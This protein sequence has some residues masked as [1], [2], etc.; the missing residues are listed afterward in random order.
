MYY[1]HSAGDFLGYIALTIHF[2]YFPGNLAHTKGKGINTMRSPRTPTRTITFA[3]VH[4]LSC[5]TIFD[6]QHLFRNLIYL[7]FPLNYTSPCIN[8][9]FQ[10]CYFNFSHL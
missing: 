4:L 8:T 10:S 5:C 6:I 1:T 3:K 9:V 7:F 2:V